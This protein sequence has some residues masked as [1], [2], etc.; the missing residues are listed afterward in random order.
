MEQGLAGQVHS[1]DVDQRGVDLENKAG[2][3][4]L[5]VPFDTNKTHLYGLAHIFA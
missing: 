1:V 3:V 4:Q 5:L 2:L